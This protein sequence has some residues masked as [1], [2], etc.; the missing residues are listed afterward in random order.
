MDVVPAVMTAMR[1]A[2]R[3]RVGEGL[4][5]PQFRCLN[6]IDR[7][8][9][10]SVGQVATFLGVSLA[11]ASVMVDR[12]KLAGHVD[13]SVSAADRRRSVLQSSSAGRR[14]LTVIRDA[15]QA[16][17][18]ELLRR[19]PAPELATLLE[20]MRLLKLTFKHE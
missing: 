13:G 18:A 7:H 8:A 16:E 9:G 5:V 4:S 19:H 3:A 11:T 20:G 12:L 17:L 6:Y 15:T 2:M 10:A 14:L 1:T